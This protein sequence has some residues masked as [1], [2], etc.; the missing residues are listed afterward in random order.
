[1]SERKGYVAT[2]LKG[3]EA[4]LQQLVETVGAEFVYVEDLAWIA[5][6]PVSEFD[7]SWLHGRAFGPAGEVRWTSRS[8][9]LT[10]HVLTE[11]ETK[12]PSGAGW[13]LDEYE[14]DGSEP[15][16]LWGQ[17]DEMLGANYERP[18]A[19]QDKAV[20]AEVRIPRP[21]TY[22]LPP[23][24]EPFKELPFVAAESI[25]YRRAGVPVLARWTGLRHSAGGER[26]E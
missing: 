20:W 2:C 25:T 26:R 17:Y 13:E 12:L 8:S 22:P 18:S 6:L 5:L 15:V 23:P 4:Q 16:L 7:P 10:L 11:D 19:L 21:L 1:M 9:E 24:P 14:A 3:S